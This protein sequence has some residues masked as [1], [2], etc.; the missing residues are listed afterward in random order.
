VIGW[1][2]YRLVT[3][4]VPLRTGWSG[5]VAMIVFKKTDRSII[6]AMSVLIGTLVG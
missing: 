6:D 5:A 2:G 4:I 1:S 3:A